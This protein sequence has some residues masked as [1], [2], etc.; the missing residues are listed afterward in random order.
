[1][2]AQYFSFRKLVYQMAKK[3]NFIT[4][5]QINT[6]IQSYGG[7]HNWV[8]R[9]DLSENGIITYTGKNK[10]N[11]LTINQYWE[12]DMPY[13]MVHISD[14]EGKIIR[15]D[16]YDFAY[17]DLK[18][19]EFV[20]TEEYEDFQ[21]V[22]TTMSRETKEDKI[23]RLE[24]RI[25]I[26]EQA[27]ERTNKRNAEMEQRA[28]E[29]FL[30]SPTYYQMQQEL[31]FFK[32][33]A[34][35]NQSHI[36]SQRKYSYGQAEKV[37]QI[38][39]DNK[40]L[41]GITDCT[42]EEYERLNEKILELQGKLDSKSI[43]IVARDK[44]I[45][46]LIEKIADLKA[47]NDV[48]AQMVDDIQLDKNSTIK[49]LVKA[50]RSET[51]DK[52]IQSLTAALEEAQ[53]NIT[54]L[55]REAKQTLVEKN[56]ERMARAEL[57]KEKNRKYDKFNASDKESYDSMLHT[58][59]VTMEQLKLSNET[60]N[61][62]VE[63]TKEQKK[64]IETLK[65]TQNKVVPESAMGKEKT[66]ELKE[67]EKEIKDLKKQSEELKKALKKSEGKCKVLENNKEKLCERREE[68][69][70]LLGEAKQKISELEN[71]REAIFS[72]NSDPDIV[73]MYHQLEDRITKTLISLKTSKEEALKWKS[74]Y[75]ELKAKMPEPPKEPGRKRIDDD[76]R[77]KVLQMYEN[78]ISM[79]KIAKDVG[80]SLGTVSNIVNK[81]NK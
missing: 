68:L 31:D 22:G 81:Y 53:M 1:M 17:K 36:E 26:L 27:V 2:I 69:L 45:E 23:K 71:Q 37:Q 50:S 75:Q 34:D 72:R 6:I 61:Q 63:K 33:L 44:Y 15:K 7:G 12:L 9:E 14:T 30:N 21:K 3:K 76:K 46:Q 41:I 10:R 43:N 32:N 11:M 57:R 80:V 16:R 47:N 64:E 58:Y 65:E 49:E 40:R 48:L 56:K 18:Q 66:E 70:K 78:D 8:F 20:Y 74:M 79:R 77:R 5:K 42:D 13:I 62:L 28:E 73:T 59:H 52:A 60:Y 67:K 54:E 39:E 19:L 51:V 29:S 4:K 38:F 24:E 55:R 35:L 25:V